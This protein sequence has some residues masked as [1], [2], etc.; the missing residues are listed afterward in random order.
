MKP[1]M[2]SRINEEGTLSLPRRPTSPWFLLAALAGATWLLYEPSRILSKREITLQVEDLPLALGRPDP[3]EVGDLRYLGGIEVRSTDKGFSG[4]SG[5]MI[6]QV[7]PDL[8]IIAVSDQGDRFGARLLM[9]DGRLSGMDS[10]VLEPLLDLNGRPLRIKQWSDAESMAQLP[11]GRVM[12]GFERRHRIWTYGP[13]LS[14]P[15]REFPTPAFLQQAPNNGGLES[16]ASWPDGRV[17]AITERLRTKGSHFAAFLWRSGAWTDLEWQP[18][19][20]GFEPADAASLPNGDLLVLER[21][22]SV[23][24]PSSLVS[25]VVRVASSVVRPGA[26]LSGRVIAELRAEVVSENLEGL[27]VFSG[28]DGATHVLMMADDFLGRPRTV[29]LLFS[30]SD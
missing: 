12:V 25:R 19:G 14:G 30:L 22:W 11:D 29:V 5:L 28:P 8:R 23:S 9:R 7:E 10:A 26:T 18:S 16:L 6:D 17:L 15:A 1:E 20:S 24:G 13:R 2:G 3:D 21:H 27:A 4:F